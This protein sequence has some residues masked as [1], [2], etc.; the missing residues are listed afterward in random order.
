[1]D[2]ER[3]L[4]LYKYDPTVI[5]DLVRAYVRQNEV[6]KAL[7]I[8]LKE[9]IR[10]ALGLVSELF[11]AGH[12]IKWVIDNVNLTDTDNYP[13]LL[14]HLSNTSS[15]VPDLSVESLV[16]RRE[17]PYK[18]LN[19]GKYRRGVLLHGVYVPVFWTKSFARLCACDFIDFV[20]SK[21][22]IEDS[23][24]SLLLEHTRLYVED[25][26]SRFPIFLEVTDSSSLLLR[27]VRMTQVG[28]SYASLCSV[29]DF[30]SGTG[31]DSEFKKILVDYYLGNK[32]ITKIENPKSFEVRR[33][34]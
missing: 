34:T 4:E 27:A 28:S 10:I 5:Y 15:S 30:L 6:D 14:Q 23:D 22:K 3:L 29:Y 19:I 31:Y 25:K 21:E 9:D 16:T 1:M 11:A 32:V 8:A 2:L 17:N 26:P 12:P 7:D 18:N 33:N 13:K 24:I 20:C